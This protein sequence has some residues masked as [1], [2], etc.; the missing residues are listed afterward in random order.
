ML[1][2]VFI[3]LLFITVSLTASLLV[4]ALLIILFGRAFSIQPAPDSIFITFYQR[5]KRFK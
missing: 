5:L 3:S 2:D 4:Y 1:A